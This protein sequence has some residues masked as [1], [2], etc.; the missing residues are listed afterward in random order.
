MIFLLLAVWLVGTAAYADNDKPITVEQLP[1]PAQ[2]FIRQHFSDLKVAYAK[3]DSEWFDRNYEVF[4]VN[5]NKVEFSKNG[6]W[7]EVNCKHSELPAGVVPVE[8]QNYV[9]THFSE[10]KMVKMDRDSRDYEVELDNGFEIKFDLRY[11]L[12]GYDD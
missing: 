10:R 3:Q 2:E 4:F 7:S 1:A 8:I 9:A 11:N 12:I 6:Q 5:G